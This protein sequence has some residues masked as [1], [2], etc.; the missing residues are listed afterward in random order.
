[1]TEPGVLEQ[2]VLEQVLR[3]D[4]LVVAAGLVAVVA[5]AWA[6]LAV[7]AGMDTDMMA[8]MPDMAPMPWTPLYAVLLFAMWWT[9]MIAM[10]VPSA[11]PTVLLYA[12][13][14]RR[15]ETAS[16]AAR[17]VWIFLAGYLL[18]W[19]GFS[20]VAVLAQ[21]A[22]ER[23]GFLSMAMA[24]TSVVLGGII[25]L[26][27]GLYQFTPLKTACLRYC[28]NPLLFL[29]R[30]WRVGGSG[31]LRMGLRH[32]SYCVGCCWFLMA[33]LFVSGVM[34]LAWIIAIA[35]YVACEKLL[36]FGR[37]LSHAAGATLIITGA[38][39]LARAA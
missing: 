37:R 14:K 18:A 27:A 5:L 15:Q 26:A 16:G 28:Q 19:A 33:L 34:N 35:L 20:L 39:L 3:R 22:L 25:L 6:Y 32:G 1:M 11:A 9:M 2:G 17:E 23:S 36:P 30:Y 38:I 8:D 21:W 4:R 24:S 12:T 7:G 31:A 29:S 10:M 13:V